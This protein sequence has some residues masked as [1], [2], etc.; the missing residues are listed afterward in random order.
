MS[1]FF[2]ETERYPHGT[3]LDLIWVCHNS[4]VLFGIPLRRKPF[5]SEP[6]PEL[7]FGLVGRSLG[8]FDS[9]F[10]VATSGLMNCSGF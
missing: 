10:A 2:V 3:H 5:V 6:R 1:L 8:W 4:G 9:V 7:Q